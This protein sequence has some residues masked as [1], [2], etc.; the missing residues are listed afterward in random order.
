MPET[1]SEKV[2]D[3]A[4]CSRQI[5]AWYASPEGQKAVREG[6]KRAK[7]ACRDLEQSLEVDWRTMEEPMGIPL[8]YLPR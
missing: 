3:Q 7:Q 6:A 4:E 2:F 8:R 1:K 5:K